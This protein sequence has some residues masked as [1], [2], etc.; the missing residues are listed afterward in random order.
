MSDLLVGTLDLMPTIL[1]LMGLDIP[2]TVQGQDLSGAVLAGATARPDGVE[3]VPLYFLNPQW[4]GVY[5]RDHT[6]AYGDVGSFMFDA[7]GRRYLGS[8]PV[9]ALYDRRTDPHQLRNLYDDP[10]AVALQAQMHAL[11]QEWMARIGDRGL[12]AV[13]DALRRYRL[14]DGSRPQ[15]V[16]EV[17]FPGR[18]I[19]LQRPL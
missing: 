17:G 10:S 15:A 7:A 5:T 9:N 16:G 14:P 1:G 8:V 3:Y 19:E 4:R 13:E 6:Y 18:P 11:T 12:R 2:K